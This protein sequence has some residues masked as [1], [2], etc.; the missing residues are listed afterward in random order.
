MV[1]I[2]IMVARHAVFYAPLLSSIG[3]GFLRDAGFNAEYSV[4]TAQRT[5]P[6]ALRDGS[7]QVGQLAVSSSWAWINS[8]CSSCLGRGG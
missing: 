7:V 8:A 3:A 1:P 2:N 4:M 6:D 5:V